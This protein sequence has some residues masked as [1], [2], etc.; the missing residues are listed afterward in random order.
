M[1]AIPIRQDPDCQ[2]RRDRAAD[3]RAPAARWASRPWPSAP[4]PIATR[5][6]RARPTKSCRWAAS[7]PGRVVSAISTRS[8]TAARRTGSDAI[9]PGY[10][11]LS[12]NAEFARACQAAG[13]AFIGPPADVI[14]AMGSKI[15][16]KRRMQTAD[17]PLLPSVEVGTSRPTQVL[18]QAESLTWPLMIKAS[19]GGGGRGMRIVRQAGRICGVARDGAQ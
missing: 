19:A 11:F 17:V 4:R 16:A 6:S 13:I 1:T 15:E 14:A 2:S 3:H 10:G 8:S 5:C 12:E 18:R 7:Q 9:H